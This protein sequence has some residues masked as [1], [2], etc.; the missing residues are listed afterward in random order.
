MRATKQPLH[1]LAVLVLLAAIAGA[2]GFHVHNAE[3]YNVS[4]TQRVH[5]VHVCATGNGVVTCSL[6]AA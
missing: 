1:L 4:A 6:A 5:I 2:K 3:L